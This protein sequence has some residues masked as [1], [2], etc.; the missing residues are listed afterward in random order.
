MREWIVVF[1]AS[2]GTNPER[3]I[4]ERGDLDAEA[5]KR[6]DAADKKKTYEGREFLG[7]WIEDELTEQSDVIKI[8]GRV[9]PEIRI[10]HKAYK[11][12]T[13]DKKTIWWA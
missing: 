3:K 8:A 6:F 9:P 12:R 11:T 2:P 4:V 5:L 10:R 13:K 1:I 7:M